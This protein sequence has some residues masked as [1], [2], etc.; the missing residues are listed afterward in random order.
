[1]WDIIVRSFDIG[2]Y[3]GQA[4]LGYAIASPVFIAE[5]L[6]NALRDEA[7]RY[8]VA[9]DINFARAR[10]EELDSATQF[11]GYIGVVLGIAAL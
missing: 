2:G 11:V 8:P 5:L 4:V 7:N 1:M 9:V 6:F 10:E 3:I